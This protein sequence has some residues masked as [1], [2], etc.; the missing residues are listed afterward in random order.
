MT[1]HHKHKKLS[2]H[3]HCKS[4]HHFHPVRA[5]RKFIHGVRRRRLFRG[6]GKWFYL[7]VFVVLVI[8]QLIKYIVIR[9]MHLHQS[10]ALIPDVLHLTYIQNQGAAFGIFYGQRVFLTSV[11]FLV[12]AIM[13]YYHYLIKVRDFTQFSLALILGGSFGNMF[14]RVLRSYVIDYVDIRVWPIFNFADVMINIG[15]ALIILNALFEKSKHLVPPS[16]RG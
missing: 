3:R 16:R 14:D 2:H 13:I 7:C 12:I 1:H 10:I 8:D 5:F 4:R 11:G 6:Y 15:V 9:N